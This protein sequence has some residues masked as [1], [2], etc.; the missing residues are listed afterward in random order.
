MM[1][2]WAIRECAA[3]R[4]VLASQLRGAG[5][6]ADADAIAGAGAGARAGDG[7]TDVLAVWEVLARVMRA[8][9]LTSTSFADHVQIGSGSGLE[10][11]A[12]AGISLLQFAAQCSVVIDGD[13]GDSSGG[14]AGDSGEDTGLMLITTLKILLFGHSSGSSGGGRIGM[15]LYQPNLDS[16]LD[17]LVLLHSF[18]STKGHR[19]NKKGATSFGRYNPALCTRTSWRRTR[20]LQ[21]QTSNP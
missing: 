18:N 11:T 17:T 7:A 12:A 16:V 20:F 13:G 1:L 9:S 8:T 10:I 15:A 5:A 19:G 4:R 14:G 3:G 6:G 21:A 2:D